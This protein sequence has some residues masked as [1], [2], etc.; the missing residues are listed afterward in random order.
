MPIS[1]ISNQGLVPQS[2]KEKKIKEPVRTSERKG[3]KVEVSAEAK[4]LFEASEQK[5][6]AEIQQRI[7][8]KFYFR[9]EVTEK[10]VDALIKDLAE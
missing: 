7:Q 6:L 4:S 8:E 1:E 3:D 5:R 10:V 2:A 9:R